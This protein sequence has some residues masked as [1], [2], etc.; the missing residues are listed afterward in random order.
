MYSAATLD[1]CVPKGFKM[2]KKF[3]ELAEVLFEGRVQAWDIKA[4]PGTAPEA[5]VERLSDALLK[6]MQRVGLVSEGELV[7]KNL[8]ID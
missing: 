1:A 8:S 5:D 2:S 3:D 7:D 6:S 4:M